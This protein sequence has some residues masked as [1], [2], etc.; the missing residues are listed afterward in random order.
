MQSARL[1]LADS[2]YDGAVSRAYYAHVLRGRSPSIVEGHDIF[3]TLGCYIGFW[4]G[5]RKGWHHPE[6]YH[7]YLM[8]AQ[9]ARNTSDYQ[10]LSHTSPK[11]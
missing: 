9:E 11:K 10:V 8:D 7:R 3:Q 1:P 4:Q 6:E 2:E 5:V